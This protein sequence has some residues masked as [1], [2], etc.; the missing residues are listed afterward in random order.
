MDRGDGRMVQR[1]GGTRFATEPF[2]TSRVGRVL[3]GQRLERDRPPQS[4]VLG[5][6]DHPHA[7]RAEDPRYSVVAD[8]LADQRFGRHDGRGPFDEFT[9]TC[10]RREERRH[11]V[12]QILAIRAG[13][14]QKRRP[15]GRV[16]VTLM[17]SIPLV[18][19]RLI[20]PLTIAERDAYCTD[21]ARVA[22][23]LGARDADVPRSWAGVR[24]HLDDTIATGTI[25]VSPQARELSQALLAPRFPVIAA[26]ATWINRLFSVGDLPPFL[27][28]QYGL[29]WTERDDRAL[30]R[31]SG[32]IRALRPGTPGAIA[33]WPQ[34]RTRLT[35]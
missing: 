2:P 16:H 12:Q 1:S 10:V 7:A 18:Y 31:V 14:G 4:C 34:A 21:A 35:N 19:E 8:R 9:R 29:S 26:P 27:R 33:I 5:F 25:A 32:L 13:R 15:L 30:T 20:A 23:A 22:L 11:L 28:A 6:V 3:R 24:R 17:E